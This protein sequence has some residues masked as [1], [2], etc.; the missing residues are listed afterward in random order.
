MTLLR[1]LGIGLA[2]LIVLAAI[3]LGVWTQSVNARIAAVEVRAAEA[4]TPGRIIDVDGVRLHVQQWGRT[5]G[6]ALVFVHGFNVNGGYEWEPLSAV[7][8]DQARLI[9]PDLPPFGHSQRLLQPDPVYT[10]RGQARLLLGLLDQLAVPSVT[11][12][13]A[14]AGG[15]TAIEMAL[16]DPERV[17]GLILIGTDVYAEGGGIFTVVGSLPAGIGRANT[18]E[19]LGAGQRAS[20]LFALGCRSDGYCPD[21][22]T[23][24][25][26]QAMAEIAGTTDAL[27]AVNATPADTGL[28]GALAE[29]T[30]PTLVLW[31]DNDPFNPTDKGRQLAADIPGAQFVLIAEADHVPHL[32]QPAATAENILAWLSTTAAGP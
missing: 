30:V 20:A 14:S 12:V 1:W 4:D 22:A 23:I 27:M 13:A 28:P 2:A 8:G 16:A 7:L 19:G 32:G 5:D 29:V 3:G 21:Q 10:A 6:P 25:R 31:G 18:F 11:V 17:T 26:R 24:D 9:V 15:D